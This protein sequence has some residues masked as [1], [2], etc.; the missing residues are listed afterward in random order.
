MRGD[1][2]QNDFSSSQSTSNLLYYFTLKYDKW[3]QR[4]T[5]SFDHEFN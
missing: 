3:N 2:Q 1:E 5:L 4:I